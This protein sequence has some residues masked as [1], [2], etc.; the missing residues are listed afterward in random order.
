MQPNE[1]SFEAGETIVFR[2]FGIYNNDGVERPSDAIRASLVTK[3]Q[4]KAKIEDTVEA[5][6]VAPCWP[7]RGPRHERPT[8]TSR[9]K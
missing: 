4:V 9:P 8:T 5:E 7:R 6:A 3:A 1:K 2:E